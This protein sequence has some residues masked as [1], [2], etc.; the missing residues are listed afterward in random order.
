MFGKKKQGKSELKPEKKQSASFLGI[1]ID[2]VEAAKTGRFLV[3]FIIVYLALA[4]LVSFIPQ[5]EIE[6][7]VA[8]G[9]LG[10]LRVFGITGSVSV[11][12]EA[13][14]ITLSNGA[15]IQISWLCTG[16]TELLVLVSAILASIGIAWKK[17]IIGAAAG[18]LA[19]IAFNFFRIAATI[20]MIVSTT[21]LGI[22]EFTHNILFR[23]FLFATIA[24]SYIAWFQWAVREKR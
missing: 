9:T 23:V 4:I 8:G 15:R 21:D 3:F 6:K 17:R 10:I 20:L 12:E 18:A 7:A 11:A 5:L 19:A 22:V 14:L 2:N 24:V 13:A 16:I 1:R